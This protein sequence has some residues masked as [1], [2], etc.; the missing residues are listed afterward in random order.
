ME[1]PNKF[2]KFTKNQVIKNNNLYT[3]KTEYNKYF[4]R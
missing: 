1:T 2:K 4:L 3:R